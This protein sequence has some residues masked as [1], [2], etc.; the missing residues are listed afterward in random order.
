MFP[1]S[2]REEVSLMLPTLARAAADLAETLSASF[3]VAAASES[4][5]R[6]IRELW[7]RSGNLRPPVIVR[8][9]EIDA[10]MQGADLAWV[11]SGT[12]V[13][14]TALRAVPQIT[15]YA[16]TPLQYRIAQRR[17]P[18][19]IHGSVTLPNLVMGREVVPELHQAELSPDNLAAHTRAL[20]DDASR[21]DAQL[22]GYEALRT[23]L[24]PPDALAQIA[25]FIAGRLE[26]SPAV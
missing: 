23:A 22:R 6:Q 11:A 17:V 14:E 21:R 20:L 7:S 24:G 1:G 12:A 2:R 18:Q 26:H 5:A 16:L 8:G 4:R 9:D 25:R 13:L 19:F 10:A 15:F 3:V